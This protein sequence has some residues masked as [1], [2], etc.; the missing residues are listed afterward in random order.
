MIQSTAFI[1][2]EA[3]KLLTPCVGDAIISITEPNRD[4]VELH[5]DWQNHVL[6]LVFHDVDPQKHQEFIAEHAYVP[7]T[8]EQAEQIT[9]FVKAQ[10]NSGTTRII[11]ACLAGI[12]RSA[13]VALS[14]AEKYKL[15]FDYEYT[16]YNH[17]VKQ[18]V[19]EA[20]KKLG[21]ESN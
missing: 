12:S 8:P 21:T 5:P 19:D 7:M 3:S 10:E 14:I 2:R 6:R 1:S 18:L 17:H 11:V 4:W 16:D 9:Q 13:G 20:W 15:P